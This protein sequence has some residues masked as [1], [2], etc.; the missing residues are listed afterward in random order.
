[1]DI[2]GYLL[3]S[4]FALLVV[5]LGW[6]N[7]ITSKSKE[8]KDLEA[9]FLKQSKTKHADYKKIVQ[10]RGATDDSFKALVNFLYSEKK[11]NAEIFEL[12]VSLKSDLIRLD[13]QYRFRFWILTLL[14]L[15]FFISGVASFFLTDPLMYWYWLLGP[16][17]V[18][19]IMIFI[20]L[21]STYFFENRHNKNIRSLM[22]KV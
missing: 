16:N 19:I 7:Q 21:I 12:I 14:S 3:A 11:D 9:D 20:N 22:E 1:M 2:A 10:D 6:A 18:L 17:L 13:K 5:L 4:G 8:T 15:C